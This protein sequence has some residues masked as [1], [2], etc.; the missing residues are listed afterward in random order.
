MIK[1]KF[2]EFRMKFQL[3]QTALIKRK[4]KNGSNV[5]FYDK[6][7]EINEEGLKIVK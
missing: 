4:M 3:Q 5:A 2:I 7:P 1:A 6:K